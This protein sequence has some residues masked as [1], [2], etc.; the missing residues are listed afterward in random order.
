MRRFRSE[1]GGAGGSLLIALVFFLFIAY[2]ATQFGPLVFAQF[3][4]QD[5][6]ID[7]AKFSRA[8]TAAAVQQEVL[9]S[10]TELRLPVT[11]D[12]IKVTRRPTHTRIEVRYD[13]EAEWLP[14]KPYKWTVVL[15]EES[16]LF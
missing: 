4:F 10:A 3:Q 2:E 9:A 5:A 13:Q 11:R 6:V 8:K 7:A 1:R 14:G 12:M 16:I 15:D